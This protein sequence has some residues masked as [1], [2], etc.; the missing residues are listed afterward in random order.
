M[1]FSLAGK[2][3]V[4]LWSVLDPIIEYRLGSS[5]DPKDSSFTI[6]NEKVNQQIITLKKLEPASVWHFGL[7]IKI[8]VH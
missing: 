6:I 8:V 1:C 3:I 4:I 7:V 2:S 5:S